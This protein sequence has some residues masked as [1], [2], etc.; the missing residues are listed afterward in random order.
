M[1]CEPIEPFGSEAWRLAKGLNQRE[2]KIEQAGWLI[3][4]GKA[5][6]LPEP[7]PPSI[8]IEDLDPEGRKQRIRWTSSPHP[9]QITID[10]D[11]T[12]RL[13]QKWL[14]D[15]S[16]ALDENDEE[17]LEHLLNGNVFYKPFIDR[18]LVIA[19]TYASQCEFRDTVEAQT[20]NPAQGPQGYRFNILLRFLQPFFSGSFNE[21]VA[22]SASSREVG[23]VIRANPNTSEHL[24]PMPKLTPILLPFLIVS[25]P[26]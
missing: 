11:Q 14:I 24:L 20:F 25:M 9:R 26:S 3:H 6:V 21:F 10:R 17:L 19:N 13:V 8:W 16:V 15:L 23:S 5:P 4:W 2:D 1:I 12:P 7:L 22:F 18:L